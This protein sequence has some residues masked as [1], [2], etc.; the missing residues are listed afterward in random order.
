M[1]TIDKR[2]DEPARYH[3]LARTISSPGDDA[4]LQSLGTPAEN[5][6]DAMEVSG[7]H[8]IDRSP[9]LETAW[10]FERRRP[11][12]RE[13]VSPDLIPVLRGTLLY[14]AQMA[15]EDRDQLAPSR[16]VVMWTLGSGL[17]WAVAALLLVALW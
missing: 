13:E 8:S 10:G 12:R 9:E 3:H 2:R 15:E 1:P 5:V 6:A 14:S 4:T 7:R 17:A 11:G 16:S